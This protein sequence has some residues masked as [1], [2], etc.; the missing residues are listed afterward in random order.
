MYTPWLERVVNN[1]T[2]NAL[3]HNPSDTILTVSLT[4]ND[5][6]SGFTIQFSDDGDGMDEVTLNRLF[7][8]YY[9]GTDTVSSSNGSGL[10]MA[11]SKGLIE[12]ME[13]RIA[14]ESS[15]GQGTI[16]KLSWS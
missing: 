6:D 1:L 14:V 3:L 9:R 4:M 2:A 11:I 15:P 13:G 8:R 16:I 7:E 12:C 10:G 5:L